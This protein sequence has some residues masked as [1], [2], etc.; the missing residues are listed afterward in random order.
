MICCKKKKTLFRRVSSHSLSLSPTHTYALHQTAAQHLN[1]STVQAA[2]AFVPRW[3]RSISI[4]SSCMPMAPQIFALH[5]HSE[6]MLLSCEHLQSDLTTNVTRTNQNH[7]TQEGTE[8]HAAFH[9]R[10][11]ETADERCWQPDSVTEFR[12]G[13][14]ALMDWDWVVGQG[15]PSPESAST[16]HMWCDCVHSPDFPSREP[17]AEAGDSPRRLQFL[18]CSVGGPAI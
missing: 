13:G 4:A 6:V 3:T 11:T 5:L 10:Y 9:T 15:Q 1:R 8:M 16:R 18:P 14:W 7:E 2:V 17:A 12:H